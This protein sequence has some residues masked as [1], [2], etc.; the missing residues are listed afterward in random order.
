MSRTRTI[1]MA[2]WFTLAFLTPASM[3]WARADSTYAGNVLAVDRAAGTIVVGDMGPLLDNGR[4]EVTP[5]SIHVPPSAEFARVARALGAAPNGWI[6]DYVET[7]LLSWDV[8]PGDFVA[9]EV[10]A[11]EVRADAPRGPEAVKVTVVDATDR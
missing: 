2:G 3:C 10:R 1:W 6:G 5:R 11:D 4:S 9:I 8:R 7:S